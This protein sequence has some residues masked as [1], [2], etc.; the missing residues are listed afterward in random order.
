MT[1]SSCQL[2][3]S[4]SEVCMYH[5]DYLYSYTC[6]NERFLDLESLKCNEDE[7]CNKSFILTSI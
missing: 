7:Q 1:C 6:Q 4:N 2:T 5:N 3:D